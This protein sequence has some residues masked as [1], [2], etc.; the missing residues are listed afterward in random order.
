MGSLGN[1]TGY[2]L[3]KLND[4][5]YRGSWYGASKN[6]IS[7]KQLL[8]NIIKQDGRGFAVKTEEKIIGDNLLSDNT[9]KTVY[10]ITEEG[11]GKFK[12]DADSINYLRQNLKSPYWK[13]RLGGGG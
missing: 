12:L 4:T 1:N 5:K 7:V 3:S 8:D 13:S 6:P 2:N 9:E 10:L 11:R